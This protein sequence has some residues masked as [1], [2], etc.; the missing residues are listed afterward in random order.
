MALGLVVLLS[1]T[2]AGYAQRGVN[3][4]QSQLQPEEERMVAR[5]IKQGYAAIGRK[6][7]REAMNN[8]ERAMIF[9]PDNSSAGFGMANVYILLREYQRAEDILERLIDLYPDDYS[10]KNNIAWLYATAEDHSVRSGPKAIELAQSALLIAPGDYHVWSTLSE[11]YYVS[12]EYEK[13]YRT[14]TEALEMCQEQKGS[15]RDLLEYRE[16][17]EKC[18]QAYEAMSLID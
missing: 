3:E 9:D 5:W 12:G 11:A 17:V 6:K 4:G 18:R 14:A 13:A 7:T 2:L 1:G 16:Q 15:E 8:F 10:L